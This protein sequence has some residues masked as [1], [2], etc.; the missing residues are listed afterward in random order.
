M[1]YFHVSL[2]LCATSCT[3]EGSPWS[4]LSQSHLAPVTV[5][6]KPRLGAGEFFRNGLMPT[7]CNKSC[8]PDSNMDFSVRSGT[9]TFMNL[10]T[11]QPVGSVG[12]INAR[13]YLAI[14]HTGCG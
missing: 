10:V 4:P 9:P 2:L 3:D 6:I 5:A 7:L 1:F 11:W 12:N 13:K 8:N 14:S